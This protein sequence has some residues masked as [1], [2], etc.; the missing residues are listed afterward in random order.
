MRRLP[1]EH[2]QLVTRLAENERQSAATRAPLEASRQKAIA[3]AQESLDAY[4]KQTAPQAAVQER[5]RHE[6]I[7]AAEAALREAEKTLPQRLA[8]W[9][10]QAKDKI[11]WT[12]LVAS[13]LSASNHAKLTQEADQAI[14]ASGPNGQATYLVVA[15]ND[16]P[17]ASG[18]RLEAL[19]DGRLPTNGPGR[20]ANG[21]FVLS[22]FIVQWHPLPGPQKTVPKKDISVTLQNAQ[23]DFSQDGYNVQTA[24]GESPDKGWAVVPR[25]GQSHTAV[26][27][28]RDDI[29]G[30]GIF[31]IRMVQNYPDGQHTLGRFRIS[32]TNAPR[33]ITF[34]QP[35]AN[36]AAIL[37]EAAD[38]RTDRQKAALLA[39]FRSLDPQWKRSGEALAAARQPLPVDAKLL[40]LRDALTE[41]GRPLPSDANLQRLRG[42]VELSAR[43]LEKTRL[44]FAQDLAWAL[45]NSPAFLFNH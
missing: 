16:L 6:R 14:V 30:P 28:I 21:N 19:A 3:Q 31:T 26:F 11:V 13:E 23:A 35:P 2:K 15:H 32:V 40:Q 20:A 9:E 10:Q 45:I 34:D 1:E 8:A 42:D 37:A 41:A 44:T 38:K 17:N 18:L 39:H 43:Q 12:P 4:E 25:T 5:E 24:L 36:I 33:P 27:E 29:G 22:Q 7:A